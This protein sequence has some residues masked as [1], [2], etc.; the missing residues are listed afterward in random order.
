MFIQMKN[1]KNVNRG[2]RL[3]SIVLL[4]NSQIEIL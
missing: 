2:Q 4:K 3:M 1:E